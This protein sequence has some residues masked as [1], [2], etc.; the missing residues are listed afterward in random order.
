MMFLPAYSPELNPVE[1]VFAHAKNRLRT[2]TWSKLPLAI[3]LVFCEI[4]NKTVQNYYER[5]A[6]VALRVDPAS[7]P[8][9]FRQ[10]AD[11]SIAEEPDPQYNDYEPGVDLADEDEDGGAVLS[12]LGLLNPAAGVDTALAAVGLELIQ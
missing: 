12:S 6:N 4:S 7:W 8:L 11:K 5:A 1:L 3:F 2:I 10:R 9:S